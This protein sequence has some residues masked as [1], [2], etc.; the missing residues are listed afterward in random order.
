[1]NQNHLILQEIGVSNKKMDE[2]VVASLANGA[3]GA[4]ITGAGGGGS[5]VILMPQNYKGTRT[6][7]ESFVNDRPIE[8]IPVKLDYNGLIVY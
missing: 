7:F 2:L 1:M 3:L 8:S 6:I 5:I 4:K